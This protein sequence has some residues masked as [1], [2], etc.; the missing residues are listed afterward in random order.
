M[1]YL[2]VDLAWAERD[3]SVPNETG[4]AALDAGGRVASRGRAGTAPASLPGR[5]TAPPTGGS[6]TAGRDARIVT[7]L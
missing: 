5:R 1:R 7:W 2:G 3:G 4:V 6:A